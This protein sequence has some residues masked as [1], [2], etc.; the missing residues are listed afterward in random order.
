MI[1]QIISDRLES[2]LSEYLVTDGLALNYRGFASGHLQVEN[3]QVKPDALAGLQLPFEL[4]SGSVGRL[5]ILIPYFE[6]Y[7]KPVKVVV[8]DLYLLVGPIQEFDYEKHMAGVRKDS[9]A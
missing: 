6:I 7:S 3:V 5:E 1:K 2:L 4:K 9:A 8:D